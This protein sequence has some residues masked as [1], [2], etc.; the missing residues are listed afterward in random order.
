MALQ[1]TKRKS[2]NIR[3]SPSNRM[4]SG[5]S[6]F[7]E[8]ACFI[9]ADTQ[10]IIRAAVIISGK[11][12]QKIYRNFP[13][14]FFITGID[15]PVTFKNGR[16]LLDGQI[17]VNTH[18]F[19]SLILHSCVSC[20]EFYRSTVTGQSEHRWEILCNSQPELLRSFILQ[21]AGLLYRSGL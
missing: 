9:V 12:D 16:D 14:S 15:I 10:E 21:A 3:Y 1:K 2:G 19:Y 4:I 7:P 5:T 13:D 8:S 11:P 6:L 17:T 20:S 18:V